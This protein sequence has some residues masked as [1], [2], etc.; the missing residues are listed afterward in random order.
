MK[1]SLILL[2]LNGTLMGYDL[3]MI[4]IIVDPIVLYNQLP[5]QLSTHNY[6]SL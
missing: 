5:A 2:L 1:N 3:V 6:K 4:F